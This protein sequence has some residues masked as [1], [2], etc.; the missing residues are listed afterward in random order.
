LY[1]LAELLK[2]LRR[3]QD[4]AEIDLSVPVF[5]HLHLFGVEDDV[6]PENF[7]RLLDELEKT[8]LGV[9]HQR[10]YRAVVESVREVR[11]P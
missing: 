2:R 4:T 5:K 3:Y 9:A 11:R 10:G 1:K 6:T 8:N 7:D